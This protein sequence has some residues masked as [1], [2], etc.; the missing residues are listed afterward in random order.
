MLIEMAFKYHVIWVYLL[1]ILSSQ[2]TKLPFT[3]GIVSIS[4]M[5][6][7]EAVEIGLKWGKSEIAHPL[8]IKEKSLYDRVIMIDELLW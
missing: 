4:S 3:R 5:L 1:P 2:I 6:V 8:I 7:S